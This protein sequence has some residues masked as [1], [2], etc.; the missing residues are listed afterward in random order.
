[1]ALTCGDE[2]PALTPR[3]LHTS[4]AQ[5]FTQEMATLSPLLHSFTHKLWNLFSHLHAHLHTF[6]SW[7][8]PSHAALFI[9]C[10]CSLRGW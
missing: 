10:Q 4:N 5:G 7:L 1:M 3:K 6:A 8:S 2:E 9:N